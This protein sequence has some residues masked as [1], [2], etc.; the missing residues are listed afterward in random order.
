MAKWHILDSD[1][2]ERA[3]CGRKTDLQVSPEEFD[4][5]IASDKCQRCERV[6]YSNKRYEE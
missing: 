3:M 6:R 1:T 5:R 2:S 4:K